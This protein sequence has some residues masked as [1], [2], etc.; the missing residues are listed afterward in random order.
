M[1]PCDGTPPCWPALRVG[2]GACFAPG[3][4]FTI[5]SGSENDVLEPMVQEFCQSR[6]ANCAV[7]YQGSLDIALALKA[8]NDPEAD[9]VWP[10][11]INLD[12]HVR[13]RSAREIGQVDCPD[14]GHPWRAALEGAG[15]GMDRCQGDD[16]GHSCCSRGRPPEIPHDL[17]YP[18]RI[19][20]PPP[21]WPMLAAG[22][23]KPEPHRIRRSRQGRSFSD[24]AR[25]AARR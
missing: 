14:A 7:R 5:L 13:H 4:Q 21:I 23:G 6:R 10:A 11:A 3:P 12:R 15:A 9:A 17:R 24:R 2:G 25:P 22:I 19:P 1:N 16:K 20:A 18:S 8:G